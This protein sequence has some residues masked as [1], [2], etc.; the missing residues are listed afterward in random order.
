M[1]QIIAIELLTKLPFDQRNGTMT[2]DAAPQEEH[3]AIVCCSSCTHNIHTNYKKRRA[4]ILRHSGTC[5]FLLR[6][7]LNWIFFF[8]AVIPGWFQTSLWFYWALRD[9]SKFWPFL[10]V[11]SELSIDTQISHQNG[12]NVAHWQESASCK[13]AKQQSARVS[14]TIWFHFPLKCTLNQWHVLWSESPFSK[15]QIRASFFSPLPA[16]SYLR[17]NV[18][19]RLARHQWLNQRCSSRSISADKTLQRKQSKWWNMTFDLWPLVTK[20]SATRR[21]LSGPSFFKKN[22]M[23]LSLSSWLPATADS[24]A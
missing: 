18:P 24:H 4:S 17:W 9:E 12:S 15:E 20:R 10:G 5:E 8:S 11:T 19:P 23:H 13:Q 6:T 14:A 1:N 3:E 7:S 22:K 2:C 16:P 21:K